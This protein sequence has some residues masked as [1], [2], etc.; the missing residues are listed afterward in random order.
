MERSVGEKAIKCLRH[1]EVCDF[2]GVRKM[3][4]DTATVWH[5]DGKGEQSIDEKL[6]QL[7][8]LVSSVGSLRYEIVRQF[9]GSHDVLQQ[10]ILHLSLLDG[11]RHTVHATM[12]MRFE[13]GLID[14]IEEYVYAIPVGDAF[15]FEGGRK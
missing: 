4:A 10:Q 14:R 7:G 11:S 13:G 3:C 5:N 9:Q 1:L 15:P 2:D 6:E 12:Y 8:L